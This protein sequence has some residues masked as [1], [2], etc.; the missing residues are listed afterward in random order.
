MTY[1]HWKTEFP[2]QADLFVAPAFGENLSTEGLT[3]KNV[4]IGDIYRWG[5]ALI[6]VTQP[7]SPCFKLS[8]CRAA[9]SPYPAYFLRELFPP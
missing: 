8:M 4:F 1:Q 6:Q 9:V 5:D 3:E 7:R 2:E